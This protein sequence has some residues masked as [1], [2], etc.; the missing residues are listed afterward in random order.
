[1]RQC[2]YDGSSKSYLST[3]SVLPQANCV[4][5]EDFN[6]KLR[7]PLQRLEDRVSDSGRFL[8]KVWWLAQ[9]NTVAPNWFEFSLIRLRPDDFK[10]TGFLQ[11]LTGCH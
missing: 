6:R 10:W 5:L 4:R 8:T 1:M 9:L 3:L 11:H 7:S 2:L